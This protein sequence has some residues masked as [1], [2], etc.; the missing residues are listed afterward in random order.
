V[1]QYLLAIDEITA[2]ISEVKVSAEV[3]WADF[4]IYLIN[5]PVLK[6]IDLVA[7]AQ[8]FSTEARSEIT[9]PVLNILTRHFNFYKIC[10]L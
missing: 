8:P 3:D 2:T 6:V 1:V 9:S 4:A 5:T 10:V 7:N